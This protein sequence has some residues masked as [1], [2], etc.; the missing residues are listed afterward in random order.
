[1][2]DVVERLSYMPG[3]R[4]VP[5][6]E[7]QTIT[8]SMYVHVDDRNIVHQEGLIFDRSRN[9][10]FTNIYESKIMKIDTKT[11]EVSVFYEFEDKRFKPA[12]VKIHKDGRLFICGVDPKSD[13]IGEHGGIYA[14]DPDGNNLT[15][16][17]TGYNVDDM[18]FD[19]EGGIYFTNYVGTQINPCGSVEYVTPDFKEQSTFISK[20]ASPNGICLSTDGN[21]MWV[22][23]TSAGILHRIQLHDL[24]HSNIA[25][26]FEG[27]Y[28][29]DS[30]SVDEDDNVYVAMARQGRILVFNPSGFLIGQVLTPGC[31]DGVLLGTTHPMV[32][33]DKA[34]LYFTVHDVNGNCGANIFYCGSFAKGNN[35]AYQFQ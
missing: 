32:H 23:E 24:W 31:E 12:A 20:L 26:R 27:F 19:A 29:P 5:H 4:Y 7:L 9:M 10:Y 13:P 35:K 21:I 22:T 16:I 17:I 33:P 14:I 30:C 25:Y 1:M 8:A 2:A 11:K 18:V 28:G 3:D 34:E 15:P 6:H